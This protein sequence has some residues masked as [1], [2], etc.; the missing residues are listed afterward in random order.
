MKASSLLL[1][2]LLASSAVPVISLPVS[3]MVNVLRP[4]EI[5]RLG[6][7]GLVSLIAPDSGLPAGDYLLSVV[8]ADGSS[9]P[10]YCGFKATAA[11][12]AVVQMPVLSFAPTPQSQRRHIRFLV[13]VPFNAP[14]GVARMS[15]S[16]A[17]GTTLASAEFTVV[18]RSFVREDLR[19]DTAMTGLR[20]NPDPRKTEQSVRYQ[21][22]LAKVNST[23][24]YY[25]GGFVMP[26][27]TERRTS[28]FAT[29]RRY[30]YS[31]GSVD[32]TLHNGI[33]YGCPVGTP[34]VAAGSGRVAMAEDRIV[35][36]KTIILEHLPGTYTIYMHLDTML[37]SE[38]NLLRR[39]DPIGTVGKTGLATGPHLHWELRIMGIASDPE[40]LIGLDK[41]SVLRT[42]PV[43]IEG[44]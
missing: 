9:S 10:Q 11:D 27:Q 20:V 35:T 15:V 41:V 37:V 16:L 6:E 36:G 29:R 24:A 44:R 7:A 14:L 39:G 17:D 38:G 8:Y 30:I 22:L 31:D 2:T 32:V 4:P 43:A 3:S 1:L 42:I 28:L 13:S 5:I 25:D 40:S 21:T 18:D 12:P 33:D 34:V 19:L 26:V 23:A